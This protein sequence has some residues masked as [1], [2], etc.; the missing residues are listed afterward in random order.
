MEGL[1][2]NNGDFMEVTQLYMAPIKGYGP[3]FN[4]QI[5]FCRSRFGLG[6]HTVFTKVALHHITS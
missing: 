4:G 3:C 6:T 1:M 5:T 2:Q